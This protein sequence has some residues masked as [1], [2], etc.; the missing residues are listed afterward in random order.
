MFYSTRLVRNSIKFFKSNRTIRAY[1]FSSQTCSYFHKPYNKTM[2]LIKFKP[3]NKLI[4]SEHDSYFEKKKKKTTRA[5]TCHYFSKS[6]SNNLLLDSARFHPWLHVLNSVIP[7]NRT[8]L[9]KLWQ[10]LHQIT[11]FLRNKICI[12]LHFG[13]VSETNNDFSCSQKW[14]ATA[15][16]NA[17]NQRHTYLF[18]QRDSYIIY[19][20]ACWNLLKQNTVRNELPSGKEIYIRNI[21][22]FSFTI[23]SYLIVVT[24]GKVSL[25]IEGLIPWGRIRCSELYSSHRRKRWPTNQSHISR[26]STNFWNLL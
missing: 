3:I 20:F 15:S 17:V 2:K 14:K 5:R 4:N 18:E 16:Q 22:I 7:Q 6:L 10:I 19:H 11:S 21:Y 1:T 8:T 13:F 26:L 23:Y 12:C 9:A 25:C 24:G